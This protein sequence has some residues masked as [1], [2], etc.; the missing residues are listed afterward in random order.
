MN[1]IKP[2][3]KIT[4]AIVPS[5]AHGHITPSYIVIHE[6][7]GPGAPARNL[8]SWWKNGGG[9][10][11]HYTLDWNGE[12]Y[13]CVPD[14]QLAWHVGGGNKYT[15]GIELCHATNRKDFEKVWQ[16]GVE[17]AA[18]QLSKRGWG[19]NR[20][21]SHY[22]CGKKW[23][24]TDHT[25]PIGYFQEYGKSWNDFKKDVKARLEKEDIE[26]IQ[27]SDI[28]KIAK[29]VWNT[30]I[31]GTKANIRMKQASDSATYKKDPT[32]RGMNLTTDEHVKWIAKV[33]K[34]T[35][36]AVK[37]NAK[38]IDDINDTL[39]ELAAVIEDMK[40]EK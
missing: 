26:M 29:E 5:G 27:E 23:G 20:L 10:P 32:G 14:D 18:W 34:D 3:Y 21:I 9:L 37:A 1:E 8:V 7:A 4:E 19:V 39:A 24:G 13:H 17:W 11:V 6:T 2:S 35:L 31:S 30:D 36:E 15:I 25:D 16:Y 40:K 38:A 12:C 33:Q 28:A 22:E